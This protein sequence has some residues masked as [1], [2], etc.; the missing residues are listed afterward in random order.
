M[1]AGGCGGV[2]LLEQLQ[3]PQLAL[4]VLESGE[5]DSD[6]DRTLDPVHAESLVQALDDAFRPNDVQ[7]RREDRRVDV[8]CLGDCWKINIRWRWSRNK[9]ESGGVGCTRQVKKYR[10]SKSQVQLFYGAPESW[11]ESWPTKSAALRN[12][13]FL[14]LNRF[15]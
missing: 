4:D 13:F 7:Q 9:F 15:I 1:L 6:G 11:P 12:L 3:P 8:R 10:K 14:N 5:A 2:V